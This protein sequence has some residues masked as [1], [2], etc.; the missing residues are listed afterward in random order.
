M[1]LAQ[2]TGRYRNSAICLGV[3]YA[4]SGT[5]VAYGAMLCLVLACGTLACAV[6]T[7]G[8]GSSGTNACYHAWYFVPTHAVFSVLERSGTHSYYHARYLELTHVSVPLRSRTRACRILGTRA[9]GR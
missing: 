1:A 5:G 4:M 7:H 3:C 2:R 9:E 8:H 6:L